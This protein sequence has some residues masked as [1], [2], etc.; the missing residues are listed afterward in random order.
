MIQDLKDKIRTKIQELPG[1]M[2]QRV[3]DSIKHHVEE[4]I[5]ILMVSHNTAYERNKKWRKSQQEARVDQKESNKA[6]ITSTELVK[7][8]QQRKKEVAAHAAERSLDSS[9]ILSNGG[10]LTCVLHP[11]IP[12][13]E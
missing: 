12:I 4:E 10:H 8:F 2:L 5:Y 3:L 1:N 6:K 13:C 7:Q 9:F 11:R